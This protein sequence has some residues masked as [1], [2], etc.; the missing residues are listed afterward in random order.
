MLLKYNTFTVYM[1]HYTH[2]HTHIHIHTHTQSH[3]FSHTHTLLHSYTQHSHV[4]SPTLTHIYTHS[5]SY[6][7]TALLP[8]GSY[9]IFVI[10]IIDNLGE[11]GLL[12]SR[13]PGPFLYKQ[14]QAWAINPPLST[15]QALRLV[16]CV[17]P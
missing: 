11:Q 6:T 3:T 16:V 4:L 10:I 1:L 15:S 17:L 14:G 13:L 5:H 7:H 8:Q 2:T 12:W 9:L